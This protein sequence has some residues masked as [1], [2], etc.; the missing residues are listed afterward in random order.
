[1]AVANMVP[2]SLGH[3]PPALLA[4]VDLA[5]DAAQPWLR[6]TQAARQREGGWV[7]WLGRFGGR[8]GSQGKRKTPPFFSPLS[9]F[10]LLLIPSSGTYF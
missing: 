6:D 1:M 9:S 5:H 8:P 10:S 7:G 4:E 2:A 3:R